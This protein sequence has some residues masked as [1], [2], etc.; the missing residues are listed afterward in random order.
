[1]IEEINL[2]LNRCEKVLS[3]NNYLEIIIAIEELQ[4][5]YR[6]KIKSLNEASN[7]VVWNYNKKDLENIKNSL[8]KYKEEVIL[9]EK[10]NNISQKI[11]ELK[12]YVEKNPHIKNQDDLTTII[13]L[14]ENTNEKD[15]SLDEKYEELKVCLNLVSDFNREISIYI[16]ELI[17]LVIR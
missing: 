5:K 12:S 6:S 13:E 17:T 9:K 1:M 2:D 10:L 14:I 7:D 4:D 3:E 8:I 11:S 15:I 16:L